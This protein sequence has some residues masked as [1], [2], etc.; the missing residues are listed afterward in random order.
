VGNQ[1]GRLSD[2]MW[3]RLYL[4]DTRRFS[5]ITHALLAGLATMTK[6]QMGVGRGGHLDHLRRL[7]DP[8]WPRAYLKVLGVIPR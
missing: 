2:P 4:K 1:V 6:P 8:M 3:P 7:S 5:Y